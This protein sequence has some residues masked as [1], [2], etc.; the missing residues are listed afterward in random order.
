MQ[1]KKLFTKWFFRLLCILAA[2][3]VV[4]AMVLTYID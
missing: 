2:L 4:T 3:L 1:R